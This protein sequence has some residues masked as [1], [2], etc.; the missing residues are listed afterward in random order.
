M[1]N[2]I[3]SSI[4]ILTSIIFMLMSHPLA[5]GLM[6]LIQSTLVALIIG[7]MMK[8][9]WFSYIL[10]LTFLGGML[11]LFIYVTSLASNEMFSFSSQT[12]LITI[13]ILFLII[14]NLLFIDKSIFLHYI[15][16]TE[17]I[18]F[19]NLKFLFKENFL[20]LNKLYNFSTNLIMLMMVMYLLL[21]LIIIVKI[22]NFNKGPLRSSS[23]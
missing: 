2:L 1:L 6:L 20:N 3:F 12:L 22:T 16:N 11:I 13:S 15:N 10:F 17:M 21:T 9:F 14:I 4:S 18:N 23:N 8:T 5:M 7:L 19:F